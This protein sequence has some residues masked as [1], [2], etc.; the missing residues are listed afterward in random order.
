MQ[1]ST[2]KTKVQKIWK[3]KNHKKTLITKKES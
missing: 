2:S 3:S 1:I